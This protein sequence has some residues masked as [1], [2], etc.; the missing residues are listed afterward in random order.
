MKE[1]KLSD[2]SL[3]YAVSI[4]NLVG[5]LQK[6]RGEYVISNQIC[7]SGTS[8]GANI[9]EAKYAA[10]KADFVNKLQ[11]ALKEANETIYWVEL[12]IRTNYLSLKDGELLKNNCLDILHLLV[13][14]VKTVKQSIKNE[15]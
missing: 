2:L 8:I 4:V 13:S 15:E 12:L 10:S 5:H 9:R 14:S 7:K 3:E 1:D 6:D 11:V